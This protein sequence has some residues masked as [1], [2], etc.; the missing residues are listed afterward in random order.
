MTR[1]NCRP[2]ALVLTLAGVAGAGMATISL[3]QNTTGSITLYSG[4][5][6]T[7]DPVTITRDIS[8]LQNVAAANGFDGTANDYAYSLRTTGRWLVCM[9]AGFSTGCFE[10]D[11]EIRNLQHNAGSISSVRYLGSS[12]AVGAATATGAASSAGREYNSS[13]GAVTFTELGDNVRGTYAVNNGRIEGLRKGRTLTGYWYQSTGDRTCKSVRGGTRHWGKLS[14]TFDASMNGWTGKWS[15]C[16]EALTKGT[17]WNG[18]AKGGAT[19]VQTSTPAQAADNWQPMYNTDL[20]GGDY[21]EIVYARP[22]SDWRTCKASCD[23]DG[24]CRGW[25]YVQPG[26]QPY[27]ECFLKNSVPEPSTSECCTSGIKGAPSS[28]GV[29]RSGNAAMPGAVERVGR[30]A[31]DAVEDEAGRAVERKVRGALGKIL[32]D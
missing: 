3:A 11:G 6:L 29:G 28:Q 17:A 19:V 2:L 13:E 23:A 25:T 9:D 8:N 24:Q 22:G 5:N 20:F 7:G 1:R 10:A 30:R 26:R 4:E 18:T 21:R 31:G 12:N 32:G 15:H 16:D 27:G 14:F